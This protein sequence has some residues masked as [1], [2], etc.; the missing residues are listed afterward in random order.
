[1]S[2]SGLP[3]KIDKPDFRFLLS[4]YRK[5]SHDMILH[6]LAKYEKSNNQYENHF[7][8]KLRSTTTT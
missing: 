2:Y 3:K 1:M 7:K 6:L 8:F 5:F 4:E